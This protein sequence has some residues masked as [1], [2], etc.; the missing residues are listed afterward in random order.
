M[1]KVSKSGNLPACSIS[2]AS[3]C[4]RSRSEDVK[5]TRSR[6]RTRYQHPIAAPA[7][8]LPMAPSAIQPAN[9]SNVVRVSLYEKIEN[10]RLQFAPFFRIAV[11][12]DGCSV[13][14]FGFCVAK[15]AVTFR[16]DKKEIKSRCAVLRVAKETMCQQVKKGE[17][18][19]PLLPP[20]SKYGLLLGYL[21]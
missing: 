1:S 9:P 21:S 12:N 10:S 19:P 20:K 5:Q 16:K 17:T 15:S 4:A 7:P 8:T 14:V 3:R 6:P 2:V 13:V 18:R 11:S